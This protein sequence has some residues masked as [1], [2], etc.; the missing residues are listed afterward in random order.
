MEI[1]KTQHT[2]T[3]TKIWQE[4]RIFFVMGRFF[5]ASYLVKAK[6]GGKRNYLKIF[7]QIYCGLIGTLQAVHIGIVLSYLGEAPLLSDQT[8][9]ILT[10]AAYL[11]F[12]FVNWAFAL[13]VQWHIPVIY[14]MYQELYIRG[15]QSSFKL[16]KVVCGVCGLT[17][18]MMIFNGIFDYLGAT[19]DILFPRNTNFLK[20][21]FVNGIVA[22]WSTVDI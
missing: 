21:D 4:T 5:G 13:Y 14:E 11:L 3:A 8:F 9:I 18:V 17:F 7:L 16:G 10:T 1:E 6:E 19:G 12:C 15:Y 20:V 22:A 2:F